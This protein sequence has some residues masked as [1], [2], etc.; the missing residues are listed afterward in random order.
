MGGWFVDIFVEY[1]F[2]AMTRMIKG[3]GS[4]AWPVAE[5]TITSSSCPRAAYGCDLAEVYYKYRVDGELYTGVNEKPFIFHNSGENYVSL[6]APGTAFTVRIK[7]NDAAVSLE[8]GIR[9]ERGLVV[10]ISRLR[11]QLGSEC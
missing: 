8:M 7:A 4:S 6:F 11:S 1:L 2:R 3:R 9:D 5:A 10:E